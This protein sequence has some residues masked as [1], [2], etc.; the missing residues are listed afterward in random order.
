MILLCTCERCQIGS[1]CTEATRRCTD[2][3]PKSMATMISP[4][5][6]LEQA[7]RVVVRGPM[8]QIYL[9]IRKRRACSF[10]G[11]IQS[12]RQLSQA[13]ALT[14]S[15]LMI[16]GGNSVRSRDLRSKYGRVS[17]GMVQMFAEH[18]F[19]RARA[20]RLRLPGVLFINARAGLLNHQKEGLTDVRR[21]SSHWVRMRLSIRGIRYLKADSPFPELDLI[22]SVPTRLGYPRTSGEENRFCAQTSNN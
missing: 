7:A 2:V 19:K 5:A 10:R 20:A 15:A 18:V 14:L 17:L 9:R 22:P 6:I 12:M 4:A 11:L 1:A 13:Q 16:R 3:V 21:I 8:K